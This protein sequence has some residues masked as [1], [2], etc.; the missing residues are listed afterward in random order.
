MAGWKA[1]PDARSN[2]VIFLLAKHLV[3]K[4]TNVE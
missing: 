3:F 2:G 4:D 1:N